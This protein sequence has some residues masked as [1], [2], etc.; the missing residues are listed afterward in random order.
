MR[1]GSSETADSPLVKA[2]HL[3]GRD[4]NEPLRHTAAALAWPRQTQNRISGSGHGGVEFIPYNQLS[5]DVRPGRDSVALPQF[6]V[7]LDLCASPPD[8]P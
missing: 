1:T 8:G 4:P 6:Q 3:G 5:G 2:E 7:G